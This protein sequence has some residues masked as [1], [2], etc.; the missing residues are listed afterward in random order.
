MQ[1]ALVGTERVQATPNTIGIC[2][3]CHEGVIPKCGTIVVHY[4]SHRSGTDCDPWSEGETPWHAQWKTAAP[5]H[6][7][8]VVRGAHRADAIAGD[9]VVCE[10]QHSPISPHDIERREEFYGDMRWIFD[11]RDR[12]FEIEYLDGNGAKVFRDARWPTIAIPRRRVMLDLGVDIGVLSCE[13][14]N[15]TGSWARGYLYPHRTIRA[16]LGG[17]EYAA[18]REVPEDPS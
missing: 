8:E 12:N 17:K 6:R 5:V 1:L 3:S 15:A 9:G 16:W 11:A 4:W 13:V 14:I 18:G 7:R 10:I 2:P